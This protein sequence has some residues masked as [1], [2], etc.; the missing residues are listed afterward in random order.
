MSERCQLEATA[1]QRQ[2]LEQLARSPKRREAD[3]ARSILCSLDGQTSAEIAAVLGVGAPRVRHW[4]GLFRQ[5]GAAALRD[6]PHPGR[7]PILA[8]LAL[9]VVEPLLDQSS[10]TGPPW[11]V[12]RLQAE[13]YRQTGQ[14]ISDRWLG[15]V[16][17]KRGTFA[18]SGHGIR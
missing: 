13:V 10:P 11:T 14:T 4:R 7:R 3:R 1:E 2:E 6:Q 5:G 15:I 9:A 8:A 18:G 17:K 16:I 12:P